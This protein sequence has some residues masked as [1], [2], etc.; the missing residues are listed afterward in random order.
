[1]LIKFARY[2]FHLALE[3]KV[4]GEFFMSNVTKARY[5]TAVL[6][7]ENMREGWEE[8][9]GDIIGLPY[10]YCIHDKDSLAKYQP[11]NQDEEYQRKTHVHIMIAFGNTTTYKRAM[12]IF[13]LLNEEGKQAL[14]TCQAC[15]SVRNTYE[16]LIHNTETCRKQG[17]YA[18]DTKE[19]I[20]GNNFDIG[21]YEQ[22]STDDKNR[23][24]KELCDFISDNMIC[25]FLDFY[26][27]A[28]AK[29]GSEYFEVIKTYSGFF[30]RLCKGCYHKA[31][32]NILTTKGKD[33]TVI[34]TPVEV[35][36]S[37]EKEVS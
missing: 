18:Y 26:D 11:K 32:E 22:L 20:T 33:A 24:A 37:V 13:S 23:M 12:T 3:R 5:W 34:N 17:K 7:P 2:W 27:F 8:T 25:N 14:N 9:I 19:R 31:R 36:V 35:D 28:L 21:A 1:M 15:N 6:Y 4:I 10:A 30:E 29:F 16:Y